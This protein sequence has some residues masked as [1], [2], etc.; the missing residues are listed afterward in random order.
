M[1]CQKEI[2][3]QDGRLT[4]GDVS[5][6]LDVMGVAIKRGYLNVEVGGNKRSSNIVLGCDGGQE[7][8]SEADLSVDIL[9]EDGSSR[10]VLE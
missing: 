1:N 9:L 6:E 2:S 8:D 10:S 5:V 4:R 7:S 3:T